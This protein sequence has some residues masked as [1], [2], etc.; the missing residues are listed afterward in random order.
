[1]SDDFPQDKPDRMRR[2]KSVSA[3]LALRDA[4]TS[5]LNAATGW[6]MDVDE[7][8]AVGRRIVNVL[9]AFN[10]RHGITPE[11]EQPSLRYGSVP[12]DGPARNKDIGPEWDGMM[13]NYYRLMGWDRQTG[14]PWPETLKKYGLE[15]QLRDLW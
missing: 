7:A 14:K 3:A 1:M 11:V 12:V 4:A 13:D 10:V 15:R 6:D 8:M 2:A 9:R 5:A